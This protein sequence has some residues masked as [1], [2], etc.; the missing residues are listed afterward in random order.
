[1]PPA[2]EREPIKCWE[3]LSCERDGCDAHRSA[4]LR[5]WLAGNNHCFANGSSLAERLA[6]KCFECP[7]FAANRS[8]SYGKRYADRAVLDTVDAIFAESVDLA[9]EVR[10]LGTQAKGKSCQVELLSEVGRALQSTME[11]DRLLLVILTAVTAGNGLGFNR[12]FLMLVDHEEDTVKGRMAVGPAEVGEADSIWKAMEKEG[13]I[14][15]SILA[16]LS[17][18]GDQHNQRITEIA[19]R[20]VLPLDGD[21]K[22]TRSLAEGESFIVRHAYRDPEA[23]AVAEVLGSDH[24]IVVP[25]VAEG[26]KL[27]AIVADNFV[28]RRDITGEDRRILETF[29]SQAALA[30][31]NASL[32]SDLRS[33]LK[34]LEIAHEELRRNHLQLLKAQTQVALGGL[35]STLIHDLRA[36]LVSIG[37][38]AR[39][40]A[41]D[42]GEEHSL[43]LRLEQIAEKALEVE[44]HLKAA[45]KSARSEIR[46]GDTVYIKSVIQDSLGL[47][48]GLMMRLGVK[49]AVSFSAGNPG[50][51]G[52]AIELR[53][54]M[55][56]L[57]QNAVEAMPGGGT[58]TV[59]TSMEGD[60][61][62]I[63]IRDTGRGIPKEV[64]PKIFSAFFTTKSEGLGLGLFS[65][66]RIVNE[67]G[68]RIKM[69]SEEGT[70][71]CFTVQLPLRKSARGRRSSKI[72]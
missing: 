40:A 9:A 23:R 29:A 63:D 13:K 4:D 17:E 50:L 6:G 39:S 21:N 57:L 49:S 26:E 54:L 19:E 36:P 72:Q 62:R 38:M 25:L 66:K 3:W 55:L 30:I 14:L 52:S 41:A 47:L 45:G 28:T 15:G 12:A 53:Q 32:H 34:E 46:R 61:L 37:L 48:R 16:G 35:A 1:M 44:Q 22:V 8:R 7:V 67:Y 33:R 56:N 11:I 10:D 60:M 20:L 43:R 24:F 58:V 65:A 68:G 51:K 70:G 71:T 27:G 59:D 18:R 31:L 69:E 2:S 5:C 42:A 64:R